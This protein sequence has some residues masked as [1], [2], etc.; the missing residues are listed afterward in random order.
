MGRRRCCA[1][2]WTSKRRKAAAFHAGEW[3][4]LRR[5]QKEDEQRVC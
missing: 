2:F 5:E 3:R 1:R 4:R